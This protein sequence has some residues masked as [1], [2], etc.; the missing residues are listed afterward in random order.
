MHLLD[1][2]D[3]G[4][5]ADEAPLCREERSLQLWEKQTDAVFGILASKGLLNVDA[6]RRGVESLEPEATEKLPYYGQY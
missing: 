5:A 6:L 2:H 3:V 4:G 1:A